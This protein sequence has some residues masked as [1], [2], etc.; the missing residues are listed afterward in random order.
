VRSILQYAP[1]RAA[2]NAHF[3]RKNLIPNSLLDQKSKTLAQ[4]I[5][6]DQIETISTS[7]TD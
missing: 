7:A 6:A 1:K 5:L 4:K 2:I 3:W